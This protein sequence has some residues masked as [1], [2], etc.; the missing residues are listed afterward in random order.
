MI[1]ES[2]TAAAGRFIAAYPL[3]TLDERTRLLASLLEVAFAEGAQYL[4]LK[5]AA[6]VEAEDIIQKAKA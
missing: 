6:G 1:S 4:A 3:L 5:V 2:T